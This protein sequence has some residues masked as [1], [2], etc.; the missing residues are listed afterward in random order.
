MFLPIE[1]IEAALPRVA[2]A[3]SPGGMLILGTYAP[4]PGP[5]GQFASKLLTVRS[6]G[7]PWGQ[8]EMEARLASLDFV[9]IEPLMLTST[10]HGVLARKA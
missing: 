3:L 6:G 8:A 10:T 9:D 4:A 5:F 7:H 2:R 1:V